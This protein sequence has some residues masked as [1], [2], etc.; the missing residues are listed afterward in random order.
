MD[1]PSDLPDYDR[2]LVLGEG[3]ILEFDT[4]AS[5]LRRPGGAFR[6]M[7]ERSA[8]WEELKA[9]AELD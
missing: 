2:I 5:L 9:A 7:C 4:P 3:R 6:S 1:L 8:D